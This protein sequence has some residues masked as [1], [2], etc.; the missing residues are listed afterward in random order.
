MATSQELVKRWL[1]SSA[2][3][4]RRAVTGWLIYGEATPPDLA[5]VDGLIDLRGFTPVDPHYFGSRSRDA[6]SDAR[7][8]ILTVR[9]RTISRVDLSGARLQNT[10]MEN[11]TLENCRVDGAYLGGSAFRSS[12]I[13]DSSFVR[14]RM[15][16][17]LLSGGEDGP[18]IWEHV[19]FGLS[20]LRQSFATG[21]IFIGCNFDSVR[22]KG[23][24]FNQCDVRATRFTGV[25]LDVLFDGRPL[26]N[27]PASQPLRDVDFSAAE[28]DGVDFRDCEFDGVT[29]PGG[30]RI[31]LI[32]N[33]PPV[34][35]RPYELAS[36]SN[37][38]YARGFKLR[39]EASV[40]APGRAAAVGVEFLG[41]YTN[42]ELAAFS[43]S[44]LRKAAEQ[45]GAQVTYIP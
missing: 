34:A 39:W 5:Q 7:G 32:D 6:A 43:E 33:F 2:T 17:S 11:L 35:K 27:A 40:K 26:R 28:F 21:G 30:H 41:E 36:A 16:G 20:D 15:N 45:E 23:F 4:L 22:M 3:N 8:G 37:S 13:S 24:R 44:L 18:T 14:A 12:R 19:D 9:D 10:R 42:P 25:M 29:L 31:L 1:D 38:Q